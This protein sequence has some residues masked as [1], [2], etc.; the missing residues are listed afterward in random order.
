MGESKNKCSV[1]VCAVENTRL[2]IG[3]D[4]SRYKFSDR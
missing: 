2:L 4:N 1:I 3:S